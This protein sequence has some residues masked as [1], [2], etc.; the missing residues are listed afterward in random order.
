MGQHTD[1]LGSFENYQ[2]PWETA[3]GEVEIDKD[4]LKRYIYNLSSDKAKAQDARDE[5]AGKVTEAEKA[6]EEA[7]AEVAKNDPD[8]KIAKLEGELTK[9]QAAAKTA[10]QALDRLEVGVEKGLTPRQAARLQ[11]ETK[12]D[13][14]KDADALLEE[15]GVK[16]GSATDED[17]DEDDEDE[18]SARQTPRLVNPN[19]PKGNAPDPEPDYDKIA[20][21]I[22]SRRF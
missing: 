18:P 8:G 3:A 1:A 12:E 17:D 11:G 14:E 21:Q 2:A 7:K 20:D 15:F 6:L 19:D 4:K 10:Q 16:A 13:F 5:S 9:A 22:A